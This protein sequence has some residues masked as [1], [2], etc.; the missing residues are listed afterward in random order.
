MLLRDIQ[1]QD[2]AIRYLSNSILSGNLAKSYLFSGP[3]GVGRALSAKAFIKTLMCREKRAPLEACLSCSACKKVE[4]L[5]HPDIVWIVPEKNKTIKIEQVRIAREAL[6]LKP[7]EA[8]VGVCVI[9]DAHCL[10]VSAANALLKI[11]EEPQ[12][13]SVLILITDK[14]ELL[15]GTIISR[16][17]EVRFNSLP[18]DIAK[19]IIETELD[20]KDKDNAE[21]LACFSQGSPGRAIEILEE[22]I[23][24]KKNNIMELMKAIIEDEHAGSSDWIHDSKNDLLED[25][26]IL[27]MLLRDTALGVEGLERL[28][29]DK[30]FKNSGL[31]GVLKGYSADKI[32]D[33]TRDLIDLRKALMSNVNSKAVACMLPGVFVR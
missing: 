30:E 6:S 29:I 16:C 5:S 25:I 33:I 26:E 7:F 3:R 9:E 11:L 13:S 2:N 18:I 12:E 10:T 21:F 27:I 1:G 19:K 23:E 31:Y 28:M 20:G 14:R 4:G 32:Y 15:L 17:S 24:E 22:G 8:P